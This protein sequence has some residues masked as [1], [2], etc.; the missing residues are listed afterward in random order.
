MKRERMRTRERK[1]REA[2]GG[3]RWERRR[4]SERKSWGG[5]GV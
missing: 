3:G 5:G 4:G 2:R 1:G